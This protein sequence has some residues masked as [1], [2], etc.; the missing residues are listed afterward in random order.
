MNQDRRSV[1]AALG[2]S[3]PFSLNVGASGGRPPELRLHSFEDAV[4]EAFGA[5]EIGCVRVAVGYSPQ[6]EAGLQGSIND[7]PFAGFPAGRLRI[8]RS[9]SA[10]GPAVGSVRLYLTTVEVAA[11][12]D[13][14]AG[15]LL[16]FATLPSAPALGDSGISTNVPRR[17]YNAKTD[18]T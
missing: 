16:D 18:R 12:R 14:P 4:R 11:S 9:S 8:V 13:Q 7:R 17:Q 15:R 10:P 1:I 2:L 3:L 5:R 6:V